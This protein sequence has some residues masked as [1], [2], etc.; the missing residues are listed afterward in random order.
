[1]MH[2]FII[3]KICRTA[4]ITVE[5]SFT[6]F[7]FSLGTDLCYPCILQILK[8]IFASNVSAVC[9]TKQQGMDALLFS[10]YG[11]HPPPPWLP[12]THRISAVTSDFALFGL[13]HQSWPMKINDPFP[14]N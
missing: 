4:N 13:E 2:A 14:L 11:V 9:F 7:F 1:M 3:T 8:D 12:K 5:N 6:W 10:F